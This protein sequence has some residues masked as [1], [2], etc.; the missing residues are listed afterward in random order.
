MSEIVTID[1]IS[2]TLN[3]I[4]IV[5]ETRNMPGLSRSKH[6]IRLSTTLQKLLFDERIIREILDMEAASGTRPDQ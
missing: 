3:D 4:G 6:S 2:T 5:L 1:S